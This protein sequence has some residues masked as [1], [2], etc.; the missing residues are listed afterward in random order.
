M[1]IIQ[2]VILTTIVLFLI[3]KIELMDKAHRDMIKRVDKDHWEQNHL[4]REWCQK[5]NRMLMQRATTNKG[6]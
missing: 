1:T 3:F 2:K 5:N 4:D 6:P